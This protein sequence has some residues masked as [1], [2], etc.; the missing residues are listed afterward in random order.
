MEEFEWACEFGAVMTTYEVK[1]EEE[2]KEKNKNARH[3]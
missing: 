3:I 2:E 1:A